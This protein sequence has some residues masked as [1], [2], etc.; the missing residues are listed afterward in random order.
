M[1][2]MT[3]SHGRSQWRFGML[4]SKLCDGE[5]V[6][7]HGA[8]DL[9]RLDDTG[10]RRERDGLEFCLILLAYCFVCKGLDSIREHRLAS[11]AQSTRQT[12]AWYRV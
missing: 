11:L 4:V 8:I 5:R 12:S 9:G 2:M 10:G 3:K 1:I 7:K 6:V